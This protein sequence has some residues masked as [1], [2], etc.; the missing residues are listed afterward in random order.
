MA[1]IF[2]LGAPSGAISD[3]GLGAT[4]TVR[5]GQDLDTG[6]L[7]RRFNFGDRVSE[8]MISQDPFFRFVSKT[9]KQST[10][11][12]AFKFTEKRGSWHKRYGYV[13]AH[14]SGFGTAAS[15]AVTAQEAVTDTVYL[16]I[17]TDY[18]NSGNMQNILGQTQS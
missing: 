16:K 13:E 14:G 6:T 15:A 12:P 2:N 5:G 1:D 9:A 11:D 8:L 3:D 4:A 18:S 7:R 17:G 10:D